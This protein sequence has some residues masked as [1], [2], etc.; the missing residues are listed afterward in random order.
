[1]S[2]TEAIGRRYDAGGEA[3]GG[4]ADSLE[5]AIAELP[6]AMVLTDPSLEDN[7]IVYVNDAFER[8]AYYSREYAI[9]RNCRFLQGEGTDPEKVRR[10]REAIDGGRDV[11][12]DLE[13]YRADGTAFTNRLVVAPIAGEEGEV[14]AFLGVQTDLSRLSEERSLAHRPEEAE[15]E[16]DT[17]LRELQ[18]R[19][20][21]HL[22]MVVSMIRM[23]ISR[24]ITRESFEALGRRIQSL[25]LLYEELTPAG[26]GRRDSDTVP[27]GAYVSRI[28]GTLGALE[29]RASIRVNVDAEEIDLPVE[30]AARLGLLLTE[31]LANAL[32]HAFE[33]R[34]EGVVRVR[35]QRLTDRGVRLMVEDDGVGLPEGSEW[36]EDAPSVEAQRD[37]VRG[38]GGALDTRGRGGGAGMGGSIVKALVRSLDA[39]LAVTSASRGT[40]ITLD[41][42]HAPT[43]D[44][45]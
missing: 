16:T 5:A 41:F 9:G 13:N 4:G 42:D 38:E 22:A 7:P 14:R 12:V 36:P 21:N 37:R 25:A 17:M 34:E 6:V 23:Q 31:F 2:E 30:Q 18:H 3:R 45:R 35:F 20:K 19:V 1:M 33:G 32:S 27:A 43:A 29:G 15:S 10:L 39:E 8:V 28:A 24:E 11:S 44:R 26:V 40:V